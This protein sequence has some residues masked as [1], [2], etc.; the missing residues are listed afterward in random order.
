M[1]DLFLYEKIDTLKEAGI[2]VDFL[3]LIKS[4]LS[5]R[6]LLREYQVDAFIN[7]T[8]YFETDGLRKNKQVHTLFHMATGMVKLLLWQALYCI[9]IPRDT[10]S[11]YSL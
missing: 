7:F 4:G 9:Y 1:A 6:I 5:K 2:S 3:D 10:E 8:L 11:F